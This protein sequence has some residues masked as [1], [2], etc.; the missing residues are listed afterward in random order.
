MVEC[1]GDVFG[2]NVPEF[3]TCLKA[4]RSDFKIVLAAA[5]ALGAKQALAE[6][7]LTISLITAPCTDTSIMCERTEALCGI[8]AINLASRSKLHCRRRFGLLT[9][10]DR[11]NVGLRYYPW[12]GSDHALE[13]AV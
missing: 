10:P 13:R 9:K 12:E 6:I 7:G 5:Y 3:L 8:S 1:G 11:R 2:A 4:R